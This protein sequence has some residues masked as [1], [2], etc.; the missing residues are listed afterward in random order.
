[1]SRVS[2]PTLVN[3]GFAHVEVIAVSVESNIILNDFSEYFQLLAWVWEVQ[4]HFFPDKSSLLSCNIIDV[5]GEK[6]G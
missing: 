6:R 5:I 4:Y 2:Y 1:M 3:Q